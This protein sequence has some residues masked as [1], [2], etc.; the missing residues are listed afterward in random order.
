MTSPGALRLVPWPEIALPLARAEDALARLD[1]RLRRSPIRDGWIART[2]FADACAALLLEGQLVHIE[3]LVLHDAGMDVRTPTHEL[4]RAHAVM[5]SR[6]R[7]AGAEPGWAFSSAGLEALRGRGGQGD[8]S[9][10]D[11]EEPDGEDEAFDP[12]IAD[13]ANADDEFSELFASVDAAIA[14]ADET[15]AGERRPAA[16][17]TNERDP[18]VYDL[19][20]DEDARLAEWRMIVD[21]TRG[22]PP[23]LAAAIAHEAWST[24]EPLQRAPGLGRLLAAALLADRGKARAH[25]PCLAE[26]A[27]A[28]HGERRRSRDASTR[29]VAELE[30]ITAAADEGLRQHDRWLLARTLL[31]R[32][33]DGRRST[34]RLPELIEYVISRP[35][36]S[37]GMIAKELDMTPRAAQNLVAELGLRE[38]TGRGRYWAWGVL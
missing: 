8:A 14:H 18:L 2:H 20:W 19:D 29:L 3:D 15:L 32:K 7:I 13:D 30:A 28:V 23:T 38:A 21:Q 17:T 12:P 33:L 6:R 5:A 16:P 25:L 26:G 22:L 4:T 31:L 10:A 35:L 34:S 36:V 37:A 1:E 24:I 9:H 11:A 27:K